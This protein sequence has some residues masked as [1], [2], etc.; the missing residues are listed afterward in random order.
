[1][2]TIGL[3]ILGVL[4]LAVIII[5][6]AVEVIEFAIGAVFFLIVLLL[7][8]WLWNKFKDKLDQE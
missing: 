2:K 1:M 8:W 5:M 3:I 6:I 7:F 4:A